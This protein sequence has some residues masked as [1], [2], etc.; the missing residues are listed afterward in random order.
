MTEPIGPNAEMRDDSSALASHESSVGTPRW[1]K[2]LGI[3]A[4]LLVVA[5]VVVLL[6]GGGNHGPSRHTGGEAAPTGVTED[7]TPSGID[8]EGHLPPAGAQ[9]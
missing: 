3:V 4:V 6:V 9:E 2:V 5:I 8:A 7:Q 1:V